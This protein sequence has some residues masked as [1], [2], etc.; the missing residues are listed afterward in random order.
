MIGVAGRDVT[1][2][3]QIL[4]RKSGFVFHKCREGGGKEDQGEMTG[5][6]ALDPKREESRE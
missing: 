3:L 5:N 6:V 4:L 1:E 2:D